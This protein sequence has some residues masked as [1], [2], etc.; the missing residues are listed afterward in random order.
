MFP[1]GRPAVSL[2]V[3]CSLAGVREASFC[4][5]RLCGRFRVAAMTPVWGDPLSDGQCELLHRGEQ[6]ISADLPQVAMGEGW[7]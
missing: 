7:P 2:G 1:G 5:E 3:T 6:W 4:S